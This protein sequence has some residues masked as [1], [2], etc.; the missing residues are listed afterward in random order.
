MMIEKYKPMTL[1][2]QIAYFENK[3]LI[4]F[5]KPVKYSGSIVVV[6]E[7]DSD[8]MKLDRV[9]RYHFFLDKLAHVQM[10]VNDSQ[11][12]SHLVIYN[13]NT[14]TF[15]YIM[16]NNLSVNVINISYKPTTTEEEYFQQSLVDEN[17][18]MYDVGSTNKFLSM[19]N[20]YLDDATEAFWRTVNE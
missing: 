15:Q 13:I 6:Y 9:F 4:R 11:G 18:F 3:E 8:S 12:R 17:F 20:K 10:V 7:P 1:S 14:N 5:I 16:K 19:Y 2:E